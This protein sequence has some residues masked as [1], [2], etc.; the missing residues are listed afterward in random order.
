MFY[1]DTRLKNPP[2]IPPNLFTKAVGNPG[3]TY[4]PTDGD[5]FVSQS[6]NNFQLYIYNTNMMM[7]ETAIKNPTLAGIK[8]R[9]DDGLNIIVDPFQAVLYVGNTYTIYTQDVPI[10][11]SVKNLTPSG[12]FA[13]NTRYY[14]YA[15]VDKKVIISVGAPHTYLLYK[16]NAGVEDTTNKYLFS[17]LT[18]GTGNIVPF[19]K[20]QHRNMYLK[21]VASTHLITDGTATVP[22]SITFGNTIPSYANI[23]ILRVNFYNGDA[24]AANACMFENDGYTLEARPVGSGLD[25]SATP[26]NILTSFIEVPIS[27][28]KYRI[29]FPGAMLTPSKV[30]VYLQGFFE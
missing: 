12:T 29:L 8:A 26:V 7:L 3:Y 5:P 13:S 1:L 11:I 9:C 30:N 4:L 6:A 22:T 10:S 2:S 21:D 16:D 25:G 23:V 28:L 20:H 19:I 24:T 14:V 27:A 15:N 17:F 18:D